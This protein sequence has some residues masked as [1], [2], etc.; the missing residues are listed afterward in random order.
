MGA[1]EHALRAKGYQRAW[2]VD[3]EY[4][5]F[6]NR[7]QARCLCAVDILSGERREVWLADK[8]NPPCP[9]AMTADECFIFFAADADIGIPRPRLACSA[10]RDRCARRVHTHPQRARATDAL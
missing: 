8:V 6:G 4:R 1:I 2:V 7:P 3:T 9:F 5:S 10:P